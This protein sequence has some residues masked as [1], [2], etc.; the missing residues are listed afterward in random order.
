MYF[1]PL[2]GTVSSTPKRRERERA[3]RVCYVN[4]VQHAHARLLPNGGPPLIDVRETDRS[5]MKTW[6]LPA[7]SQWAE[8]VGYSRTNLSS[9][10][11][12]STCL[13]DYPEPTNTCHLWSS[14]IWPV[15]TLI[16]VRSMKSTASGVVLSRGTLAPSFSIACLI[17]EREEELLC[18]RQNILFL[19]GFSLM[20]YSVHVSVRFM[21]VESF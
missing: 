7:N 8:D 18:T 6:Q 14:T 12:L 19:R 20:E 15:S 10:S 3:E 16:E 17:C 9:A 21:Y 5:I 11:A 2:E 1:V 4:Y 13:C